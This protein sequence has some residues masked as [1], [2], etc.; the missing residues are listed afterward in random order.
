[1]G[2]RS[3]QNWC[4]DSLGTAPCGPLVR[5][6]CR[7]HHLVRQRAG[8]GKEAG[9]AAEQGSGLQSEA[10]LSWVVAAVPLRQAC[11]CLQ[12]KPAVLRSYDRWASVILKPWF[13]NSEVQWTTG[14]ADTDHRFVCILLRYA[15]MVITHWLFWG[16]LVQRC[17]I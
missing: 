16:M 3:L 5:H 13:P 4:F 11:P 7:G 12:I 8:K 14:E 2:G 1:V 15:A 6:S 17:P 10:Q 9:F